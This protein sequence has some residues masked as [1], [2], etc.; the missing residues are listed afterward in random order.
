MAVHPPASGS[1]LCEVAGHTVHSPGEVNNMMIFPGLGLGAVHCAPT[2]LPDDV[3]LAAAAAV[4]ASLTAEEVTE[5][6]IVP[7]KRRARE[8][9]LNVA[10][11]V[12]LACQEL[13][14][15]TKTLGNTH[16]EIKAALE[17]RMW[18]PKVG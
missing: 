14:V 16:A 11:A 18:S 2:H 7:H 5:H 15:S 1:A 13:G 12:A 17:P 3:L 9:S 8:V 4:A 10:A 6:R